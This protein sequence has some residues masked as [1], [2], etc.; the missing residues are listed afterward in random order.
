MGKKFEKMFKE[1][2]VSQ[3]GRC[4]KNDTIPDALFRH[5]E[6]NRGLRDL[7]GKGVLTG[8]TNISEIISFE[9][10]DGKRVPIDGQLWYRGYTVEHLIKMFA[11]DRFAYEILTYLLLFGEL[12]NEQEKR[13]HRYPRRRQG[14]SHKILCVT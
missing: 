6:V 1:Y 13:L 9:E 11:D 12:P 14:P 4:V 3:M 7:D 2:A 8:L 5:Y 10:R